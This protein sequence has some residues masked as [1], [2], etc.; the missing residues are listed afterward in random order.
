MNVTVNNVYFRSLDSENQKK[1]VIVMRYNN[2]QN[3]PHNPAEV[4]KIGFRGQ[5]SF[6]IDNEEFLAIHIDPWIGN[7]HGCRIVYHKNFDDHAKLILNVPGP[8]FG[9]DHDAD[10][11]RLVIPFIPTTPLIWAFKISASSVSNPITIPSTSS[12][13]VI[14]N[15]NP[16][17]V[18]IGDDRQ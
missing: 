12:P 1:L 17:N 2:R 18:E 11:R 10:G 5:Q 9:L 16:D 15:V 3:W 14:I 4:L 8:S 13:A 7:P 6:T